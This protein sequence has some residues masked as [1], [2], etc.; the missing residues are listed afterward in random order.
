MKGLRGWLNKKNE[1]EGIWLEGSGV[2]GYVN[3]LRR[4]RRFVGDWVM[5]KFASMMGFSESI[6]IAGVT[7]NCK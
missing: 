6:G 2:T 5:E 7:L 1:E 4:L 3:T